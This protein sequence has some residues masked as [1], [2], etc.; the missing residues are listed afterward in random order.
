MFK[1]INKASELRTWR[2]TM[3][4]PGLYRTLLHAVNILLLIYVL[5]FFI[6]NSLD[7]DFRGKVV[8][9]SVSEDKKI[10]LSEGWD[11][12][13]AQPG[14]RYTLAKGKASKMKIFID[15]DFFLKPVEAYYTKLV[16][17]AN[18]ASKTPYSETIQ[19]NGQTLA[20]YN[21][22]SGTDGST[23]F[24]IRFTVPAGNLHSGWNELSILH[25]VPSPNISFEELKIANY[26][27]RNS[28]L[29]DAYLLPTNSRYKLELRALHWPPFWTIV[30]VGV[31]IIATLFI[32]LL[33]GVYLPNHK[34][35]IN[36][37]YY[38][39]ILVTFILYAVVFLFPFVAPYRIIYTA[40]PLV[41]ILALSIFSIA[42]LYVARNLIRRL[43]LLLKP[44]NLRAFYQANRGHLLPSAVLAVIIILVDFVIRKGSLYDTGVS[45]ISNLPLLFSLFLFIRT[46]THFLPTRLSRN[47]VLTVIAFILSAA[48]SFEYGYYKVYNTFADADSIAVLLVDKNY[49]LENSSLFLSAGNILFFLAYFAL[50][51][52]FLSN[53]I[54][55][56]V[57]KTFAAPWQHDEP[58][59]T[60]IV[61]SLLFYL[62]LL[63][64]IARATTPLIL[65]PESSYLYNYGAYLA[66][67][68][69]YKIT[70]RQGRPPLRTDDALPVFATRNGVNVLLILT[71]SLRRDHL[72]L[73]GYDRQ[74]TPNMDRLFKGALL[75]PNAIANSAVTHW[76][77][78]SI[79]TG[80]KPFHAD[81]SARQSSL[82][83]YYAK[84]AGL[85]T[86]Y[87]GSHWLKWSGGYDYYF[88]DYRY[89]DYFRSPLTPDS[90]VGR[91]DAITVNLFR[92]YLTQLAKAD[93]NFFGVLHLN[94]THWP[95]LAHPDYDVYHPAQTNFSPRLLKEMINSYD[96][97]IR[98]LDVMIDR[99][100]QSLT[101]RGL[102]D[103]TII[104]L[105]SDHG[106]G[107]YEHRKYFHTT[108]F[109]QE[110][111]NVP[112]VIYIPEKLKSRFDPEELDRL[113]NNTDKFVSNLDL[114]PTV[115]DM[116][117]IPLGKRVEGQSLLGELQHKYIGSISVRREFA[118]IDNRTLDKFIVE[119]DKGRILYYDLASD[120]EEKKPR[121]LKID[122]DL[123]Y[124][125][126]VSL[127]TRL[128][129]G[130][131][132]DL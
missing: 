30:F 70:D 73:F 116:L 65:P 107:F 118:I 127:I 1:I 40:Q 10:A 88:L 111:I 21:I 12:T 58:K 34:Q 106:E 18:N 39:S 77:S 72:S 23:K 61:T 99:A 32:R 41:T 97:S 9:L 131:L 62:V 94:A 42:T 121:I 103:S 79:F 74:T 33:L 64:T 44:S 6:E 22:P 8:N 66:N 19:I 25:S 117:D 49:W 96:N 124:E 85:S 98:Y 17:S 60:V 112:L 54:N 46:G 13:E 90:A 93:T 120:P 122:K 128:Q 55:V 57:R 91:D 83:W 7:R 5:G 27:G 132:K 4:P 81:K 45:S 29:L 43:F 53:T 71:E 24:K 2:V 31:I 20:K 51:L 129:K 35:Q 104:I 95:Y 105:T 102:D 50:F 130:R 86:F 78:E 75:F 36:K 56:I 113:Q 101:E 80:L 92:D 114:F 87:I 67:A 89:L 109:Y 37:C 59:L 38:Y 110:G 47:L 28:G 115:L 82:L 84:Q 100:I 16:L 126:A 48:Y 3:R 26:R 11:E 14:F 15:Q 125:D 123:D 68:D 76:S 52:G 119:N 69:K 108:L 63:Q